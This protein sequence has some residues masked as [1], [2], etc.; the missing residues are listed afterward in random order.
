MML[1]VHYNVFKKPKILVFPHLKVSQTPKQ[2][3]G[4]LLLRTPELLPSTKHLIFSRFKKIE[5]NIFGNDEALIE[6]IFSDQ[7]NKQYFPESFAFGMYLGIKILHLLI[8]K[9]R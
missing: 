7:R 1:Y 4:T 5:L 8:H 2:P 9:F 3:F 6:L